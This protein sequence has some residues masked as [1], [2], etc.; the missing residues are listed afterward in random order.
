[1]KSKAKSGGKKIINR[2]TEQH[3]IDEGIEGKENYFGNVFFQ[4][5]EI[6]RRQKKILLLCFYQI[7]PLFGIFF[8]V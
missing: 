3:N 6:G 4:F 5:L 8:I 2:D 7:F 1:M